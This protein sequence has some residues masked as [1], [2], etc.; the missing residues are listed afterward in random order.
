MLKLLSFTYTIFAGTS[1]V[2]EKIVYVKDNSKCFKISEIDFNKIRVFEKKLY[3]K[4]YNSY[5]YYGVYEHDNE[6]I[7]LRVTLKDVVGCS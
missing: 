2:P 4:K 1:A 5:K 3:S 6:Y 7:P